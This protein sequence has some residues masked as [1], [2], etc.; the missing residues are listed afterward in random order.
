M[1]LI[2]ELIDVLFNIKEKVYSIIKLTI[3]VIL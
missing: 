3:I 2:N 1:K